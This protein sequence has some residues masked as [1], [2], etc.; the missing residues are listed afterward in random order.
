MDMVE[1]DTAVDMVEDTAVAEEAEDTV[2]PT[3][4]EVTTTGRLP[5]KTYRNSLRFKTTCTLRIALG[6]L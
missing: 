5:S 1:G 3:V 2:D 4:A 6:P